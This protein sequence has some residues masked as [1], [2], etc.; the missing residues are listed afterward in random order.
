MSVDRD[1]ARRA[2]ADFLRALGHDPSASE[3]LEKTPDRVVAA[4]AD[5]LLAGYD[6]DLESLLKDG[7]SP[8]P[9]AAAGVPSSGIDALRDPRGGAPRVVAVKGISVSTV[10][11]HHLLPAL[12]DAAVA[13]APGATVL[14]LGTIARLV[15]AFAR[16]LTLQEGIGHHVVTTLMSRVGALGAY[17][18]IELTHGCLSARGACQANARAVTVSSAG[19]FQEASGIALLELALRDAPRAS[20]TR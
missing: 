7:A 4:F 1:A 8:A 14:G 12:G 2:I 15:D 5:E 17:C 9:L 3:E 6:V 19:S 18:R 20:E 11:P 16:R 10:C 13:Y